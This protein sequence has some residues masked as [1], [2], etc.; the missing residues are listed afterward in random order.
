MVVPKNQNKNPFYAGF[1]HKGGEK[2]NKKLQEVEI[3][4]NS[5]GFIEAQIQN[6]EFNS[7]RERQDMFGIELQWDIRTNIGRPSSGSLSPE[8]PSHF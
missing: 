6:G 2:Q 5:F 1:Q 4:T 7:F 8:R 3:E